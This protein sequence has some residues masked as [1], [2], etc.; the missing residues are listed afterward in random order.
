MSG[1]WDDIQYFSQAE[2]TCTHC[3]EEQMLE[4]FVR[5]IDALRDA[6]GAPLSIASGFRCPVHN[7]AVSSTGLTGP[8]TTGCAAD[9]HVVGSGAHQ[10]MKLAFITGF[11]GVGV[12]QKGSHNSRFLHLDVL[13]AGEGRPRPWVWSY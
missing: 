3:G 8:H 4:A 13:E 5:K 2:F 11:S 1:F 9:I 6:Y 10:L 12:A 7:N